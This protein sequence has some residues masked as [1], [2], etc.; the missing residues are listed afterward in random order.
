MKKNLIL[1]VVAGAVVLAGLVSGGVIAS[2]RILSKAEGTTVAAARNDAEAVELLEYEPAAEETGT[3]AADGAN[4]LPVAAKGKTASKSKTTSKSKTA[5][6][7]KAQMTD[8]KGRPIQLVTNKKGVT[9]QAVIETNAKGQKVT[10][11]NGKAVT[12]KPTP[13]TT[14]KAATKK[15]TTKKA[16]A[17]T[18][19]VKA[20]QKASSNTRLVYNKDGS[21]NIVKPDGSVVLSYSYSKAG[22]YF[23]TDDN[24]WQRKFGFNRL[25]DIGA[26]FTVLYYDT[27]R[28]KYTYGKYDW[29]IQMWKG[30][31]G[32][33]FIGSEIGLYYK[34]RAKST[35]HYECATEDMEMKMQMTLYRNSKSG[36]KELFTRPYAPHWWITAF[37]PG[38]LAKFSDRSELTM[39]GKITFH[40]AKERSLF[41]NALTKI[42]DID[43]NQFKKGSI[44]KNSAETYKVNGNTVDFVWR[45]LDE[46]RKT[47][48]KTTTSKK[49][50]TTSS[51]AAA[52]ENKT[53]PPTTQATEPVTDPL[54]V[55][56][57]E[58]A[59][60]IVD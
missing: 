24:P 22:N 54:P 35:N 52:E 53:N 55:V 45:Y 56:E 12:Q 6:K 37:V 23:Y 25:Y 17:T 39:I 9:M 28:V 7:T 30:Q 58:T 2:Q 15:A 40:T 27:V 38:K 8:A 16:A 57:T 11:A 32:W 1:Y 26:A 19:K 20:S 33:I 50:E 49:V 60:P 59:K 3:V 31:Y 21:A 44:N 41:V 48:K 46:D 47:A 14:K 10:K 43:G 34:D 36:S 13:T 42:K 18:A 4:N 5:S 29:M 51:T